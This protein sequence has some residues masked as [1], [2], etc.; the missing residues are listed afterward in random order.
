MCGWV[1]CAATSIS[2]RNRSGPSV[3]ASSGRNTFTDTHRCLL[4]TDSRRSPSRL[5]LYV[6]S[7]AALHLLG[8]GVTEHLERWVEKMHTQGTS[9]KEDVDQPVPRRSKVRRGNWVTN[10]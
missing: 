9:P 8:R 5:D 7:L 1:S 6:L 10:W 2:R 3:A 4:F